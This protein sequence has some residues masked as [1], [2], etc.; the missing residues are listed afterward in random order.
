LFCEARKPQK[1]REIALNVRN[2]KLIQMV[3]VKPQT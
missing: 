1:K 3:K 2:L